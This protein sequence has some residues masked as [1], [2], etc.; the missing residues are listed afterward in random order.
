MRP[1][2]PYAVAKA[3]AFWQVANYREGYGLY[4]ASG[5]LFNHESPLRPNRF[6]VQK[7]V[8]AARRIAQG[9]CEKLELG[10]LSVVRDWGWATEYVDAMWRDPAAADGRRFRGGR[11]FL[12]A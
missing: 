7:S 4:C 1:R 2:S 5:I 8:L 6:V 10:N 12:C 3:A 11:N 9:S